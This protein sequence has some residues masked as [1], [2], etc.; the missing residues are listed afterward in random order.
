MWDKIGYTAEDFLKFYENSLNYILKINE[1]ETFIERNAAIK[2]RKILLNED[3]NYLDLRSPCGAILGQIS[4][5][6]DGS[7][8]SCD[9]GRMIDKEGKKIFKIGN[10]YKDSY[11]N[12]IKNI[13]SKNIIYSSINDIYPRCSRCAFKPYCGICPVFN[14]TVKNTT[15]NL[16][17]SNYWCDIEKGIFKI[18][19]NKIK[20]K[21][22][23][24]IFM[25]W[26]DA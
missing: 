20:Y 6:P 12:V 15:I 19:I 13:N 24:K 17:Y 5:Y 3:P 23:Y 2:L 26:F 25:R 1:K 8:Y 14:Y 21:K 16:D 11:K 7:I 4:Y 18:L 9:E 10:V 22:Y